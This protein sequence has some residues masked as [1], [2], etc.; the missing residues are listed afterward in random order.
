MNGKAPTEAQ[1]K[2]FWEW[3]GFKFP[4][5]LSSKGNAY[6][7]TEVLEYPDG[8]KHIVPKGESLD[9]DLNNLFEYAP[10]YQQII[11][12]LGYCGITIDDK[13]YEGSGET[14]GDALFW[15]WWEVKRKQND[16]LHK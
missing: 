5:H 4:P 10:D 8:F 13:L 14:E 2:G 11:F 9:I 12:Q 6:K 16:T 1:I 15:A 7:T 3:C